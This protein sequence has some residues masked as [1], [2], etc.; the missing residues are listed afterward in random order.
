MNSVRRRNQANLVSPP[1]LGEAAG[2][3]EPISVIRERQIE[4]QAK[5]LENALAIKKETHRLLKQKSKQESKLMKQLKEKR[6][7]IRM[8]S[9]KLRVKHEK[10]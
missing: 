4:L 6:L 9:D 5:N 2:Q 7:D 1:H 3:M 10:M 8:Q